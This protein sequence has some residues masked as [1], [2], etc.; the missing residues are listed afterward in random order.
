MA[1]VKQM[2]CKYGYIHQY[3]GEKTCQGHNFKEFKPKQKSN[4]K[5]SEIYSLKLGIAFKV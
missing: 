4:K 2:T 3:G 1:N 5:I